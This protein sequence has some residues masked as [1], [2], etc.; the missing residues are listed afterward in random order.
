ML[1]FQVD[2]E[3]ARRYDVTSAPIMMPFVEFLAHEAGPLG[4]VL[5]LACGTGYV[6]DAV[7]RR[8]GTGADV[9]A[10]DVNPAMLAVARDRADRDFTVVRAEASSLPFVDDTFDVVLCQ[11]GLQFFPDLSAALSEIT[12]VLRPGGRLLATVWTDRPSNPYLQAQAEAVADAFP[13]RP[14]GPAAA[15]SLTGSTFLDAAREVGLEQAAASVLVRTVH[16][17]DIRTFAR[18]HF[19]ALP[20]GAALAAGAPAAADLVADGVARRLGDGSA[21]EATVPFSSTVLRAFKPT[22]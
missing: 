21:R 15:F 10:S 14:V 1:Q 18:D 4:S 3:T 8:R 16:F 6:A 20:F 19:V 17:A 22:G 9:V 11:Q 7:A 5:D 13:D 12:R 2:R